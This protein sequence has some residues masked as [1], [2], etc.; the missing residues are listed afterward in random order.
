MRRSRWLDHDDDLFDDPDQQEWRP[1]WVPD[2]ETARLPAG[3]YWDAIRVIE[4]EAHR[5]LQL[6]GPGIGPVIANP[7]AQVSFFLITTLQELWE[8]TR[9]ARLLRPGTVVAVPQ[10]HVRDGPDVHWA[11]PPGSGDTDPADLRDALAGRSPKRRLPL[12]HPALPARRK[13]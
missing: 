13:P 3:R 6:L 5:A 1:A 9:T 4:P 12:P 2:V 11:V 10:W 8:P 7:Y